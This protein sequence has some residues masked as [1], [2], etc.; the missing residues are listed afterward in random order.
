MLDNVLLIVGTDVLVIDG[1]TALD[2]HP[3]DVRSTGLELTVVVLDQ[4]HDPGELN[5]TFVA[6]VAKGLHLPT[7]RDEP[8]GPTSAKPV[9]TTTLSR[10]MCE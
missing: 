9:M 3:A 8:Q 4:A 7:V 6:E 5:D 2:V 1:L 10:S